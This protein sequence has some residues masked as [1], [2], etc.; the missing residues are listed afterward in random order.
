MTYTVHDALTLGIKVS[1]KITNF[2][3]DGLIS[4]QYSIFRELNLCVTKERKSGE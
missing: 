2:S 1:D 3:S 4:D